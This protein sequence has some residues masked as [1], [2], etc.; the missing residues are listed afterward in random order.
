M[1]EQIVSHDDQYLALSADRLG[2]PAEMGHEFEVRS[3]SKEP[4]RLLA[5]VM[6]CEYQG[7]S[8]KDATK[9]F[10]RIVEN[11]KARYVKFEW[12]PSE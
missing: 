9:V 3:Y 12:R 11:K 1:K 2:A 10:K 4:S 7:K 8:F 6:K 5:Y